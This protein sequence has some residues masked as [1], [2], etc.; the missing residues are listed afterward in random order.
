MRDIDGIMR[1]VGRVASVMMAGEV[2]AGWREYLS[3]STYNE[4][5]L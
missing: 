2:L 4:I 1:W 3:T 5:L